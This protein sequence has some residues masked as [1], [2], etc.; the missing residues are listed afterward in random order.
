[1]TNYILNG[2]TPVPES[3]PRK[4][5]EWFETA[6]RHVA[7]TLLPD[8]T[9]ISTV[10]LGMDHNFILSGPPVLF[11]TMIF[12]GEHDGYQ[13]RYRTWDEAEAGHRVAVELVKNSEQPGSTG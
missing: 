3:N 2:K 11:E 7:E 4:W 8:G 10:F 1:M 12:G 6:N 9:R 5:A 13:E